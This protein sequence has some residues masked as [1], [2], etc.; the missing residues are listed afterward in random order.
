MLFGLPPVHVPVGNLASLGQPDQTVKRDPAADLGKRVV[1]PFVKLPD[2][3][4]RLGPDVAHVVAQRVEQVGA[5]RI[6]VGARTVDGE[7]HA[8]KQVAVAPELR[9]ADGAIAAPGGA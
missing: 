9:L 1:L 6:Q 7:P 4:V 8:L 5:G 2:P 3:A